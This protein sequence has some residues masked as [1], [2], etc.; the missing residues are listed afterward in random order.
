MLQFNILTIFPGFFD[1]PL[2][3]GLLQKGLESGLL[4]VH[5]TDL[6]AF[7][8]DKHK[9][10]DAAAYGGGPGMILKLEPIV[11]AI[12]SIPQVPKGSHRRVL[13]SPKGTPFS[14]A[15]AMELAR[16]DQLTMLCGRYEG[17]DER[18]L[19][20]GWI[21]EEISI[22]DYIVMGGE[23]AA[24]VVLEAVSRHLPGLVGDEDSVKNDTFSYSPGTVVKPPLLKFPQYTRPEEFRG[25]KVPPVLLSGDHAK[26][27]AWRQE[28]A[29]KRTL[30]KRPDLLK[31]PKENQ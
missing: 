19:E 13:L 25:L 7:A 23:V 8:T 3:I 28:Q 18:V 11:A 24:L 21:D 5:V 12:E 9:R 14:Q 15:K 17:V 2:K 27:E 1:S 20:G 29:L 26:V 6:R 10:V 16:T 4:S 22:G 31:N 30:A